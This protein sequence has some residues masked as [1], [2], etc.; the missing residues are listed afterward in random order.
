MLRFLPHTW[1]T[2]VICLWKPSQLL[3]LSTFKFLIFVLLFKESQ[4]IKS[5]AHKGS[6]HMRSLSNQ[7]CNHQDIK[8][9]LGFFGFFFFPHSLESTLFLLRIIH[10]REILN[11][12]CFHGPRR[13]SCKPIEKRGAGVFLCE[14]KVF[15]RV[16]F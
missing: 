4:F 13:A 1:T 8:S 5:A 16:N 6:M 3:A 9:L 14:A 7:S 11:E 10:I 12:N 2:W 15:P